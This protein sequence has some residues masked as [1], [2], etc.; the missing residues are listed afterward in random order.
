MVADKEVAA[1]NRSLD[2]IYA[3]T[4]KDVREVNVTQAEWQWAQKEHGQYTNRISEIEWT[5]AYEMG[6]EK[7]VDLLSRWQKNIR[8]VLTFIRS[9]RTNPFEVVL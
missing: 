7:W 2:R 8:K 9:R 1:M 6:P 4:D 3:E 5:L